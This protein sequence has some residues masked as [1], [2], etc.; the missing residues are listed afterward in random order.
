MKASKAYQ[1]IRA[2]YGQERRTRSQ[3][4]LIK[5][6]DEGLQILAA[7]GASEQAMQAYCLHPI[8][9]AD[10]ALAEADQQDFASIDPWV[11]ILAMEYRKTANAYLS[12]RSINSLDEID[13]SPLKEVNDMLI[14]DKVQNRKDFEKYHLGSHPRSKV[15][16]QYFKNWLER[17]ALSEERYEELILG[18]KA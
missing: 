10:E 1:L 3:V 5:H 11:L 7:I 9:Q 15:L 6:I 18:I 16:A 4:L 13:L 12:T 8:L 14:A 17:L 2:Y